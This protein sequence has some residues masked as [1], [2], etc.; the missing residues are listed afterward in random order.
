MHGCCAAWIGLSPMFRLPIGST[1]EP[2]PV[3]NESPE[4]SVTNRCTLH[5]IP[6]E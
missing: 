2:A 1:D 6:G 3:Y 5:I 4:T